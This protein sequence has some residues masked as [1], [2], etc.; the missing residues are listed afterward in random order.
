MKAAFKYPK[1]I[2]IIS[3]VFLALFSSLLFWKIILTEA[4]CIIN[5]GNPMFFASCNKVPYSV[6]TS[7][8]ATFIPTNCSPEFYYL[9]NTGIIPPEAGEMNCCSCISV[10]YGLTSDL[11]CGAPTN[12]PENYF[13]DISITPSQ[14]GTMVCCMS[15]EKPEI[16]LFLAACTKIT[17]L[18]NAK[19]AATYDVYRDGVRVALDIPA[20]QTTFEDQNLDPNATYTYFVRGKSG[21]FYRDSDP[22]IVI[23]QCLPECNFGANP[24]TIVFPGKATLSWTCQ[25]TNSCSLSSWPSSGVDGN[26]SAQETLIVTPEAPTTYT[27]TCTNAAGSKSFLTIL[28]VLKTQLKETLPR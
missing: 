21:S 11:S 10:P 18:V 27:L 16:S 9:P 24:A 1:F 7:N 22:L 13:P 17:L 25:Y 5:Q 20:S 15:L 3:V 23:T 12:C 28:T 26:Y 6:N 14:T 19:N 4:S 8:P 2:L